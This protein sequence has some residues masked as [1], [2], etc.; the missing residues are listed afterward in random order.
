ME[1]DGEAAA[2]AFE[3]A[4][5][6]VYDEASPAAQDLAEEFWDMIRWQQETGRIFTGMNEYAIEWLEFRGF[7]PEEAVRGAA[8][9]VEAWEAQL[10]RKL[11]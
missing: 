5:R 7:S 2:Q 9:I 3:A 4:N 8:Q 11:G 1:I 6:R 10:K